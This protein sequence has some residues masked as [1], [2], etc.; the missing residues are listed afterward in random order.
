MWH[1]EDSGAGTAEG[2]CKKLISVVVESRIKLLFVIIF[3]KGLLI[4]FL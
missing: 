3:A 2:N 1:H 4:A